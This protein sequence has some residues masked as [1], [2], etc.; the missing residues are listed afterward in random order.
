MT[1]VVTLTVR[2]KA[3]EDF[4]RYEGEAARVMARHGGAIERVVAIR[5]EE[6]ELFREVHIVTFPSQEAFDSYRADPELPRLAPLRAAAVVAT[7]ITEK[8]RALPDNSG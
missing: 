5:C 2:R 3:A 8:H 4:R 7:E 1:L 6:A